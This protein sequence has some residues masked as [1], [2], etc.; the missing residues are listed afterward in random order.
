MDPE[1]RFCEVRFDRAARRLEGTVVEWSD[2]ATIAGL[3]TEQIQ[4]GAL[5]L[6]DVTMTLQHDRSKALARTAGGGLEL[7]DDA[8]GLYLS[9]TLPKTALA[10]DALTLVEA[11]VLRGLS[12]ELH[13][14]EERWSNG[15]RDRLI[16]RA[17]MPRLSLVDSPAY[18][19]SSVELR[20]KLDS[21]KPEPVRSWL[22][23]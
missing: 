4:R 6:S 19:R 17:R 1:L 13:V 20:H 21:E 15:N 12:V 5:D 10:D 8:T 16:I 18:P 2:R 11:R 14:D 23:V 22:Y 9:A 3:F 7:R